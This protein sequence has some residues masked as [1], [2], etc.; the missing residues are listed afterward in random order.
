MTVNRPM[1]FGVIA[2]TNEGRARL[3]SDFAN[4]IP[5]SFPATAAWWSNREAGIA[6]HSSHLRCDRESGSAWALIGNQF[7]VG[8]TNGGSARR[9]QIAAEEPLIQALGR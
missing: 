7:L 9:S 6:M 3:A 5:S 8:D 1:L 2:T 4:A